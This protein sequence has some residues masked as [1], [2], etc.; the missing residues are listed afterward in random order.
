MSF[1]GE[2][3]LYLRVM[4]IGDSFGVFQWRY[5]GV[6]ER[7]WWKMRDARTTAFFVCF[8]AKVKSSK[9]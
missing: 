3:C 5:L 4:R 1:K 2:E 7:K 8:R 9:V 6:F